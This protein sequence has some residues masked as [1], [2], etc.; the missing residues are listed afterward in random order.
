MFGL[1]WVLDVDQV[2]TFPDLRTG[3]TAVALVALLAAIRFAALPG[4]LNFLVSA[5]IRWRRTG[6]PSGG[7]ARS[8][9]E[10]WERGRI[11]DLMLENC[12]VAGVWFGAFW[13][14]DPEAAR[15]YV[16]QDLIRNLHSFAFLTL[17]GWGMA[18]IYF[19]FLWVSLIYTLW[20]GFQRFGRLFLL[21]MPVYVAAAHAALWLGLI[22]WPVVGVGIMLRDGNVL[23]PAFRVIGTWLG[24]ADYTRSRLL[25]GRRNNG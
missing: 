14:F 11:I 24:V 2:S 23:S 13:L 1:D 22:A 6:G 19:G 7:R 17:V 8:F 10:A 25:P 16:G 9:D 18:V 5:S 20:I 3:I 21:A 15:V 12:A 4:F